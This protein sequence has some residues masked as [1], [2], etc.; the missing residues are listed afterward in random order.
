MTPVTPFLRRS[1]LALGAGVAV[2][3]LAV[4]LAPGTYHDL[5]DWRLADLTAPEAALYVWTSLTPVA[6]VTDVLMAVFVFLLGKELWEAL[7]RERGPLAGRAAL[8]PLALAAGGMA[9]AALG[10][11]GLSALIETAEEAAGAPGWLVP[12]GGSAVLAYVFGRALFGMGHPALQVLL[13]VTLTADLGALLLTGLMAPGAGGLRALWLILPLGAAMA[14]WALVTRPLSQPGLTER[15]RRRD[16][17]IWPWVL[18]GAVSWL[19]VA[20]AGLPPALGL[21]PIIPAMPQ[22]RRAFGLFATAEGFLTDPLNRLA[23]LLMAPAVAIL[24]LF[25]LMQGGLDLG[26]LAPTTW[27]AL[28]ALLLAKPAGMVAVALVLA[29]RGALPGGLTLRETALV[30]VLSAAGFT[31]PPLVAGLALPGGIMQEAARLGA[32]LSVLAGPAA[33]LL[34][35]AWR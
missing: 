26:A 2:A 19:G 22:A 32:A 23:H 12:L 13:F 27:V 11:I 6:L 10:W 21:L 14:G 30:A 33:L 16:E 18:A 4:N 15:A 7:T 20:A 24:F 25:G 3:T 5:R 28:G 8:A 31:V 29:A 17:A 9:G 34:A 35:R 1:A